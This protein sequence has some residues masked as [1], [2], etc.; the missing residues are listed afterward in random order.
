MKKMLADF[1][2]MLTKKEQAGLLRPV[3][4]PYLCY[5]V[6]LGCINPQRNA[7]ALVMMLSTLASA[8]NWRSAGKSQFQDK[9]QSRCK[10]NIHSVS[11]SGSLADSPE[12]YLYYS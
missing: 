7:M 10:N 9:C 2:T 5:F 12:L 8:I 6:R 3:L 11:D 1:S 4:S